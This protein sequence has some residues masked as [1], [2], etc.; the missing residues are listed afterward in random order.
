[1]SRCPGWDPSASARSNDHPKS[2]AK[3]AASAVD[4]IDNRFHGPVPAVPSAPAGSPCWNLGSASA[5][6]KSCAVLKRSAG[7]FSN[8][9]AVAAATCGGTD[10]RNS[11]TGRTSSVTIF[12]TIACADAPVCGGSPVNIS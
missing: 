3:V 10:L 2:R 12:I 7:S 4:T 11:V 6:V 5:L 8:A 9:L 1:M